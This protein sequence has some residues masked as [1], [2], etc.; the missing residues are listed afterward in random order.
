MSLD[1]FSP[2]N[3]NF[4]PRRDSDYQLSAPGQQRNI[5]VSEHGRN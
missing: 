1:K 5:S 2:V 4:L 3:T